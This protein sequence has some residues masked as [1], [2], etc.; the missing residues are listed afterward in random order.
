[1]RADN[2]RLGLSVRTPFGR[3]ILVIAPCPGLVPSQ[4]AAA[5][6]AASFRRRDHYRVRN[7]VHRADSIPTRVCDRVL[8][9]QVR[10]P[11]QPRRRI[12][13]RQ[14]RQ[15]RRAGGGHFKLLFRRT[16]RWPKVANGPI[17]DRATMVCHHDRSSQHSRLCGIASSRAYFP[18]RCDSCPDYNPSRIGP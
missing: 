3:S 4:A 10:R 14:F 9:S 12:R 16:E 6:A 18:P 7:P 17:Q 5:Y 1:V 2:L 8:I 11:H 13:V 15:P